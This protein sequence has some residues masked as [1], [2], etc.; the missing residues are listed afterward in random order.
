MD[1][2]FLCC[3]WLGGLFNHRFICGPIYK[4]KKKCNICLLNVLLGSTKMAILRARKS[5][6][7]G[8]GSA[9]AVEVFKGMVAGPMK[10]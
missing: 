6:L 5:K 10:M 8:V 4:V 1:H 3:E 9:E 7:L 2:L